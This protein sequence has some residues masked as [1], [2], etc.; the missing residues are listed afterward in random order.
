[1]RKCTGK[2]TRIK[3]KAIRVVVLVG[4]SVAGIILL[5]LI[6]AIADSRELQKTASVFIWAYVLFS[7]VVAG[8]V[9]RLTKIMKN[10]AFKSSEL[11]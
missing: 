2:D 6:Q 3:A 8:I 7:A 9:V 1:M 5:I 11:V 4:W 10:A